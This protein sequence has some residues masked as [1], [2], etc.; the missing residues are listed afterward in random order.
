M[1]TIAVYCG[2]SSG[3]DATFRTKAF[4]LG[5]ALANK[6]ISVVYGGAN[7]GLM[8]SVADGAL[9]AN[10][11]VIGVMPRFLAVKELEHQHLS[12]SIIVDTMHER[13]AKMHDLAD[14]F[15]ALPGGFGTLEELFE[16]LTWAQLSIHKKPVA[17]LNINGYYNPLIEMIK[18]MNQNGFLKDEYLD[19]LLVSDN[20]DELIQKMTTYIPS[21]NEKW[22]EVVDNGFER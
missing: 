20:T 16:M 9:A 4:E 11:N 1:K 10:G 14:G 5:K 15:I 22:F 12:Q 19:L 7:V 8:G 21:K 18:V 17:L 13:K 3:S 6:K 2:S